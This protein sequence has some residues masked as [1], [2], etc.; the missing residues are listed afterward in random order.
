MVED[1]SIQIPLD[2]F[3]SIIVD[4]EGMDMKIEGE[5][6]AILLVASLPPSYRRF[7]EI[8]L[9]GN[10]ETLPFEDINACLLFEKL[11]LE[12]RSNDKVEGLNVRVKPFKKKAQIGETPIQSLGDINLANFA[13]IIRSHGT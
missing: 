9:Y 13:S 7:K 4:L 1:T 2:K 8:L 3:N 12:M 11:G 6:K 10:N 5:D